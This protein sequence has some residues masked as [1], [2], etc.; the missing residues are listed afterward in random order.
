[1]FDL[2]THSYIRAVFMVGLP[3]PCRVSRA[4]RPEERSSL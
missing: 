1:M 4:P 3:A 2:S